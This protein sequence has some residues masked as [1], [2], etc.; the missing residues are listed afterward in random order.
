MGFVEPW[1]VDNVAGATAAAVVGVVVVVALVGGAV[2]V[3]AAVAAVL[4]VAVDAVR[5]R[6]ASSHLKTSAALRGRSGR[7]GG[8]AGGGLLSEVSTLSALSFHL[9]SP[10]RPH[11][12]LRRYHT[13]RPGHDAHSEGETRITCIYVYLLILPRARINASAR[14]R[15]SQKRDR[16]RFSHF[17]CIRERLN[18]GS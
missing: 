7:R 5:P 15:E 18:V 16:S 14:Q 8:S 2:V 11:G 12:V 1:D 6:G 4:S 9:Y 3:V 13:S 17:R 10:S